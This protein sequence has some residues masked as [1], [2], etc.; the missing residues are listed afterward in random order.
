MLSLL[1][2]TFLSLF[3]PSPQQGTSAPN[4]DA[5]GIYHFAQDVTIPK[6]VYSVEAEFSEKANKRKLGGNVS[7]KFIVEVDGTVHRIVVTR[8]AAE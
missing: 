8:S 7:L 4:P 2:A 5:E 3:A 6:L 1:L